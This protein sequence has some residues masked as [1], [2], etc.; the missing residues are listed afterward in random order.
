MKDLQTHEAEPHIENV[1]S[2]LHELVAHLRRD[3]GRVA[4]ATAAALFQASAE[5]IHGLEVAYEQFRGKKE[6]AD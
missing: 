6:S 1:K 3:A 2:E 4:D 5:V